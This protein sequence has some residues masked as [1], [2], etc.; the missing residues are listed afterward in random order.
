MHSG[1]ASQAGP[2]AQPHPDQD[3]TPPGLPCWTRLLAFR[4]VRVDCAARAIA[5]GIAARLALQRFFGR[6]TALD[7]RSM[8]RSPSASLFPL[9]FGYLLAPLA[10]TKSSE[11]FTR[12]DAERV[13]A[14]ANRKQLPVATVPDW[15][16]RRAW[17][18]LTGGASLAFG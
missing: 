18:R 5:E 14:M 2:M 12:Q 8:R 17:L 4:P 7:R 13:T 1:I 16:T 11:P 9:A 3:S 10:A 6:V 15:Q